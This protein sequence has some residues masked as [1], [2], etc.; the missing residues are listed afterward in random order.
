MR[1]L[2]L[3]KCPESVDSPEGREQVAAY[4]ASLPFPSFEAHPNRKGLL[5]RVDADGP[6]VEFQGRKFRPDRLQN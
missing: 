3:S 2:P 5:V 4:L 1:F 6:W